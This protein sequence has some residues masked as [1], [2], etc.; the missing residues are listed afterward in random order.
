MK[1]FSKNLTIYLLLF[2]IVF[3]VAYFFNDNS[4]AEVKQTEIELSKFISYL[5]REMISEVEVNGV[6]VTGKTGENEYVYCYVPSAYE[7]A[8]LDEQYFFPMAKEGKIV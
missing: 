2:A 1:R 4:T 6:M 7:I 5:D 8:M 3:G